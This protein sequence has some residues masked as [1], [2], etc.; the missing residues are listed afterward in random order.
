MKSCVGK[1]R[2]NGARDSIVV[3]EDVRSVHNVGA[4]FR[5]AEA[6]GVSRIYLCGVSP[7]PFDRFGRAR[8]DFA[9]TALGA[10]KIVAW[11]QVKDAG[12]I[13]RRLKKDGYFI[14][15]IEQTSRSVDF[16]EI[17]DKKKIVYIFGNEVAG[18]SKKVL[19]TADLVADI[20][21]RG[22][23]ESL[24]VSVAVGIILFSSAV[25]T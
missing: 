20:P 5:T 13:I 1:T 12:A 9:K 18:V 11:E 6:V 15:A 10:E 14:C 25:L 16:R 24:N 21:M 4:I 7:A 8:K 22:R 3:L 23:K 2:E 17:P 19:D